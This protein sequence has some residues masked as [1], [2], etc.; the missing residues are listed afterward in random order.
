MPLVP[1]QFPRE[2]VQSQ[3]FTC[4]T[5]QRGMDTV[6]GILIFITQL[7]RLCLRSLHHRY[8]AWTKPAT[9]SLFLGTL[10]YLAR[11]NSELVEE[12]QLLREQLIILARQCKPP[13]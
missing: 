5:S 7:T 10:T 6:Q 12:N 9:P 4:S 2:S 8:L 1:C 11:G 3:A 13:A